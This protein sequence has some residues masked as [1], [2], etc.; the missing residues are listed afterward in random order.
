VAFSPDGKTLAVG[1]Y[2]EILVWD[3]VEGKLAKRIGAGQIGTMVRAVVFSK[4]GKT[5]A[6]AEGTPYGTGAVRIFDLQTGQLVLSFQEPKG[7]VP[8]LALSPDGKLLVGGCGDAAAYVW[9]LEEKRLVTKL[10]DH[11]LA[12]VSASFSA[13][14]KYLATASLDKTVQVWD[15]ATWEP[16]RSKTT[17]EAPVHRC[18][19]RSVRGSPAD[20]SFMFGMAVGGHDSRTLQ[21]RLDDRAPA[22]ARHDVKAEM[23][24]GTPLDC[25]WLK[26]KDAGKW[27]QFHVYVA[28]SDGTVKVFT[29]TGKSM[30][31][32]ATLRGH[33]D[34]VYG[35]A[36]NADET[37]V[38]SASGDGS[39]KLWNTADGSPLAT[40]VQ[41]AAG[42]D[43]WLIVAGRGYF[44][45]S[46]PGAVQWK[47][48]DAKP[49]PE[50]LSA[51]QNPDMLR[52]VLAGK[53]VP[54]PALQ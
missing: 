4:D 15:T 5:V 28:A 22:W 43:D 49:P 45:T 36:A 3:L 16:G 17:A 20:R 18:L 13:D 39:V 9:N 14:G 48:S 53:K 42:K 52:Q 8:C 2:K 19:I 7:A 37:R 26:D 25:L 34:W 33:S 41:L 1:G 40:L 47:T 12:V 27:W 21:L 50:K 35:L 11:S 6:A 54:P 23:D 51:L 32:E 10:K 31:P 38:A 30:D 24:A 29:E 44:A 46:T